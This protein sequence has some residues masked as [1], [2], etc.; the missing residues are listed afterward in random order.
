MVIQSSLGMQHCRLRP[1]NGD[2]L[3]LVICHISTLRTF[4]KWKIIS[5]SDW[6][7]KVS[8]RIGLI[9]KFYFVS[10]V[11]NLLIVFLNLKCE[12]WSRLLM[13]L[14]MVVYM[15]TQ[16]GDGFNGLHHVGVP[17]TKIACLARWDKFSYFK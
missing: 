7:N 8:M 12:I 4:N 11:C 13:V 9:V 5:T 2:G 6:Y 10:F 1:G 3:C 14:E 16:Y 17:Q 15:C